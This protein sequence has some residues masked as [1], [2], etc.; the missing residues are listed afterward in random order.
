MKKTICILLTLLTTLS[1]LSIPAGAADAQS[2][3][4]ISYKVLGNVPVRRGYLD[5]NDRSFRVGPL[6]FVSYTIPSTNYRFQVNRV[7]INK[8]NTLEVFAEIKD[9]GGIGLMVISPG[10]LALYV[11]WKDVFGVRGVKVTYGA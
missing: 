4:E 5:G 8:D 9:T 10:L 1:L 3:A 6:V 7:E 11:P 2:G